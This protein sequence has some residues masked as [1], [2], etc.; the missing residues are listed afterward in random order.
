M[1]DNIV[2]CEAL[3]AAAVLAHIFNNIEPVTGDMINYIYDT[4]TVN[5][6][7]TFLNDDKYIHYKSGKHFDLDFTE[8]PYLNTTMFDKN[9]NKKGLLKTLIDKLKTEQLN[10][11]NTR[12]DALMVKN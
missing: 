2:N 9:Q 5:E 8:Y 10:K 6:A 3:S 7:Q 1:T 11:N 4:I 12:D